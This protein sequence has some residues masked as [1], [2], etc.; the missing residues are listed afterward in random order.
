M[1]PVEYCQSC[2][3]TEK[4]SYQADPEH[5]KGT[6]AAVGTI[7]VGRVVWLK[8]GSKGLDPENVTSCYAEGIG[9]IAIP[10]RHL[11]LVS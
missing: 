9:I 10:S 1:K 8:Q 11:Q 3:V 5:L 4:T 2:I 6:Q 7:D